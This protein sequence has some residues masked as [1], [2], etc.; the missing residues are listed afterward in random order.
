[1]PIDSVCCTD[2]ETALQYDRL[3][4]FGS[5]AV[6]IG[7]G[8]ILFGVA[9]LLFLYGW[10]LTDSVAVVGVVVLL[11]CI[12]GA[13]SLFILYGCRHESFA[14][15]HPHIDVSPY[16]DA[17][18][19]R[20]DKRFP[21]YIV[22]GVVLIFLGVILLVCV[23]SIPTDGLTERGEAVLAGMFFLILTVAV[24]LMV[25]GGMEHTRYHVE[26]YNRER[27]NERR[28]GDWGGA[29]MLTATAIFLLL[30]F[31]KNLWHPAW[32]VFP[33]GGIL[34]GIISAIRGDKEK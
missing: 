31:L 3:M 6:S 22:S 17:A 9:A 34:T 1:L 10:A 32:I 23:S 27:E 28:G 26:S 24:S 11:L 21:L 5:R 8:L 14:T 18:I 20:F 19:A 13:V 25:F 33:I 15:K 2:R 7:V 16:D 12:A 30:G 4:R 29:I